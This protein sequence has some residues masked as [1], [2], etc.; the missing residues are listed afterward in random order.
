M[1]NSTFSNCILAIE[2]GKEWY[3]FDLDGTVAFYDGWKGHTHIGEP[4]PLMIAKIKS[5]LEM[6][7]ICKI[8]TARVSGE[9]ETKIQ[10]AREAIQAYCLKH[11]GQVLEVT[12]VKDMFMVELNDDRAVGIIPNTG[13]KS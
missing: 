4:I 3:A 2:E 5:Y 1:K 9:D 13:L 11:I 12:N 8:F 7:R 6:G 10:E